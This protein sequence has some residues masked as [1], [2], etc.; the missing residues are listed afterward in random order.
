LKISIGD[1]RAVKNGDTHFFQVPVNITVEF[2]TIGDL[3]GFLYNVEK[4]M[5]EK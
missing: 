5:V 4:K 1:P 3:T 2:T